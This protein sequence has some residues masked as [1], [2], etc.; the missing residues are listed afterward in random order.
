[1]IYLLQIIKPQILKC[2][3]MQS[4]PIEPRLMRGCWLNCF[5]TFTSL[6]GPWYF[7]WLI[8]THLRETH[9]V[10]PTSYTA[11]L[12]SSIT[13]QRERD[14]ASQTILSHCGTPPFLSWHL[15][16]V[17]AK[18]GPLACLQ[19]RKRFPR[20]PTPYKCGDYGLQR[21]SGTAKP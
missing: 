5:I 8:N 11:L 20:A 13:S 15:A 6:I 1:M 7:G 4:L 10:Q 3:G 17:L 9:G 21:G 2:K 12:S 16:N 19:G 18:L 14:L